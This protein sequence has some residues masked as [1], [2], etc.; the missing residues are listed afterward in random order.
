MYGT[1][2]RLRVKP[3]SEKQLIEMSRDESALDIPGFIGQ[4]V[5]RMDNDPSEYYLVVIFDNRETYFANADSPEQDA[6]YRQFRALLASDPEWHDGEIVYA[7][8]AR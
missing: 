3:G 7:D 8:T 1:V 5:Y 4:Y 2:A 6:R